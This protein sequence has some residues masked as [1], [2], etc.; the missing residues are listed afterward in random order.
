MPGIVVGIDGS[1]HSGRASEWAMKEAVIRGVPL[2]AITAHE[3]SVGY[4]GSAV[5]YPEDHAM[6]EHARQAAQIE[7]DKVLGELS[8]AARPESVTVQSVSGTPA[9]VLISA[10]R[11]ADMIV[12]GSR[13]ASGFTRLLMGSVSTQVA[14]HARCPVTVIPSENRS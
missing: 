6:A 4:W 3:I 1:D 8:E 7:V 10:A 9:E 5:T 13:G 12:V 14:Q 2:T 11:D